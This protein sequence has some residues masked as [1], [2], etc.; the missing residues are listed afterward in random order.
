MC[1]KDTGLQ[2]FCLSLS[3]SIAVCCV[4]SEGIQKSLN[5]MDC[6]AITMYDLYLLLPW[7]STIF[8]TQALGLPVELMLQMVT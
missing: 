4:I 6:A 7:Y 3:Y 8:F 5:G 2:N 1:Q